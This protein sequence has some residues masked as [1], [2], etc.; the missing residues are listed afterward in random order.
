M[1]R[2][3]LFRPLR[4]WTRRLVTLAAVAAVAGPA[5]GGGVWVWKHRIIQDSTAEIAARVHGVM[6]LTTADAGLVLLHV[7]VEGRD[8]TEPADILTALGVNQGEPLMAVDPAAARGRLEALPW[9]KEATVE[10]RLPDTIHIRLVERTPIAM[11]QHDGRYSL[12]D[13]DGR[14]IDG[15]VSAYTNLPQIAGAGAPEAASDLFTMLAAAPSL[16]PR[17]KAAVRVGQRRWDL[18]VDDLRAGR[19]VV[20]HLP[21]ANPTDALQRLIT[22]EGQQQVLERDIT[23]VDLRISDRLVV[24]LSDRAIAA[25]AAAAAAT[26]PKGKGA[27]QKTILPHGPAQDT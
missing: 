22:L 19:G 12:V 23:G 17:V 26:N 11:W 15:D 24:Q 21:E 4:P 20:V 5:V 2:L 6:A 25:E 8:H 27:G 1:R 7:S 10:R 16:G 3:R 9:V 14:V 18:W 13:P